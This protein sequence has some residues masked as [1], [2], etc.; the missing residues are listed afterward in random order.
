MHCFEKETI[1]DR[2]PINLLNAIKFGLDGL[3][4]DLSPRCRRIRLKAS[5]TDSPMRVSRLARGEIARQRGLGRYSRLRGAASPFR[6]AGARGGGKPRTPRKRARTVA[7]RSLGASRQ[8][9]AGAR[10]RVPAAGCFAVRAKHYVVGAIVLPNPKLRRWRLFEALG[11]AF[12][13]RSSKNV[14]HQ[15]RFLLSAVLITLVF[16]GPEARADDGQGKAE[17]LPD[18][19]VTVLPIFADIATFRIV[20]QNARHRRRAPARRSSAASRAA[21]DGRRMPR[22]RQDHD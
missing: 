6:A 13:N 18:S 5:F 1:S 21:I 17:K 2:S 14:L 7:S 16:A 19:I 11:S 15:F 22:R 8:E 20:A 10:K 3:V 9:P 12:N 4:H